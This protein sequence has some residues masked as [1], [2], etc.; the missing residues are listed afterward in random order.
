M[1]PPKCCF[2][3]KSV[4]KWTHN[5]ETHSNQLDYP[6]FSK[7]PLNFGLE[8]GI[9]INSTDMSY[10]PPSAT[11]LNENQ[12][13]QRALNKKFQGNLL[14][15]YNFLKLLKKSSPTNL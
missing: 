7:C 3:K 13:C 1:T 5:S 10:L 15:K 11:G 8:K 6:W 4:N 14:A 2:I 9:L 12:L